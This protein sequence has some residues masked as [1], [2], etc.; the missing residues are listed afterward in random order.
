MVASPLTPVED[1]MIGLLAE[2]QEPVAIRPRTPWREWLAEYLP[3][4]T[5]KP[6]G[7]RHIRLWDWFDS[8]RK[9]VR[10]RP[11]V[12]VWPRG[13]AKSTTIEA[14]CAWIGAA[15][16]PER[17]YVLYVSETQAQAD[18]HV[19]AIATMLERAGI[20]RA[21]NEYGQSKGWRRQ[22]IRTETGFNV[23]AFG[24]DSGL[25]GVKLDE[26]RPDLII[27]DDIDG[28]HD[29]EATTQ[30]KIDVL[31]ESI[32]PAGS[33]DVAIVIVQNLIA[34]D[35]I[36]S[37]LVD[38]RADFLHTRETPTLEPA[39][40]D[41]EVVQGEDEEGRPRF[42]IVAGIPTWAGQDI[43]TCED[44]IN[45][46]GLTAFL[47]E[48]Q[49]EVDI[50]EGGL[51]RRERDI[52]PFRLLGPV[53]DLDRIVVAVDPNAG[54]GGDQ[55][56]IIVAGTS[57][58]WAGRQWDEAH[59][60]VLADRTVSGGPRAWAEEAVAA[61]HDYR[62]DS[63]LAEVNNGGEMVEIT[64][65]TIPGAPPVEMVYASR[66]KL[67]R[68]EPVQVLYEKGRVHHAG[69][70]PELEKEL[71]TWRPGDPSPNRLDADVWALTDLLIDGVDGFGELEAYQRRAIGGR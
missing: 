21:V 26:Y 58:Y 22:E 34:K 2:W 44:Q 5:E 27:M 53:P 42:R 68:A 48:A 63:L 12:E 8:L 65:G 62:A 7:D 56:G 19:Q 54:E 32:L 17:H 60:Y 18:K 4:Y 52:E 49:Q 70:F 9:G 47:R 6:F 14:A 23:T 40:R 20:G 38:G 41:L 50:A 69:R 1:R 13:G 67:T 37:R 61:Y 25:R 57:Y 10:P 51:W 28:R 3:G 39:I 55:A 29:T 64:I 31:T 71:C 33:S 15:D 30:K 59:A 66:S 16:R 46:W 36:V 11:R 35:S 45:D 43:A 24:L